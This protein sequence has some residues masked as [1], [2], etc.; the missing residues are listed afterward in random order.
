MA[1]KG[2]LRSTSFKPGQ[3]GNPKGRPKVLAEVKDLARGYTKEA[4]RTLADIAQ[5]TK[6]NASARVAAASAILDRGWGK[7][8]QTVDVTQHKSP[9]DD[10]DASTLAALAEALRDGEG[11]AEGRDGTTA[12]H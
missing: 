4:I 5:N 3:S 12:L 6:A 11:G 9:L 2:G 10:L 8:Q 1:G 7:P